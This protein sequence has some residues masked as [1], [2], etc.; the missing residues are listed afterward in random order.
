MRIDICNN[1]IPEEGIPPLNE[2][3][4]YKAP[5]VAQRIIGYVSLQAEEHSLDIGRDYR[6]G[7]GYSLR[8]LLERAAQS[9]HFAYSSIASTDTQLFQQFDNSLDK[10]IELLQTG[11]LVETSKKRKK[12]IRKYH[13]SSFLVEKAVKSLTAK[14][15]K[16][17]AEVARNLAH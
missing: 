8:M 9:L 14:T 16:N 11:D 1:G 12:S 17:L 10:I 3:G 13:E 6:G 7:K 5:E 15:A 4:A 2:L